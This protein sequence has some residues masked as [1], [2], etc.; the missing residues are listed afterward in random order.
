MWSANCSYFNLL[1]IGY[2][3]IVC[4]RLV[5][6]IIVT[7]YNNGFEPLNF[8][9]EIKD[10]S[11]SMKIVSS[12]TYKWRDYK[13]KQSIITRIGTY[14]WPRRQQNCAAYKTNVLQL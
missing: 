12:F 8:G 5:C 11:I 1:F 13:M 6:T 4:P 14:V 7:I 3:H 2:L 10:D 9:L